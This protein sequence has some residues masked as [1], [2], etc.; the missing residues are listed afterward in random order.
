MDE[1]LKRQVLHILVGIGAIACLLYFGR[2]FMIAAVFFTIIIGTVLINARLLGKKIG[3]V[4]WFERHFER[5][6]VLFPGWG[7]ACYA[8]GVLIPLAFLLDTSGIA[9]IVFI[10]AVGDGVST[11]VGRRGRITLPYNEKKTL[12]GSIAFLLASLP[13]YYFIGEAV[14]PLALIGA[15]VE[16]IDFGID[17]NLMIP[18]ACTLVVIL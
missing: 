7:S 11:A 18:I 6:G 8:A 1:E 15:L 12:E 2:G 17:D 10:L 9:A 16:G 13:A 14:F 4:Q 5:P 3:I